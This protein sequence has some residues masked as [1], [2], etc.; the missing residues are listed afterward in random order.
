MTIYITISQSNWDQDFEQFFEQ[1][2]AQ[3][4]ENLNTEVAQ[5]EMRGWIANGWAHATEEAATNALESGQE[6]AS[7]NE[8]EMLNLI[9]RFVIR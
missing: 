4:Y 7:I 3:E 6:V 2:D 9:Q 5:E 1:H 8:T